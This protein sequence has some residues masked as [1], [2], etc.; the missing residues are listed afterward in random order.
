MGL[1]LAKVTA[2]T[3]R[4]LR[5]RKAL[6]CLMFL[7][8]FRA[9]WPLDSLNPHLPA[10]SI[11]T[12]VLKPATRQQRITAAGPSANSRIHHRGIVLSTSSCSRSQYSG[13]GFGK[14]DVIS[15]SMQRKGR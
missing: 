10:T 4:L 12:K 15:P 13:R 6:F 5:L 9:V 14:L 7:E 8:H 11:G 2:P 3:D 1:I